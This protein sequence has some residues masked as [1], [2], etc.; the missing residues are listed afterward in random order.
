MDRWQRSVHRDHRDSWVSPFCFMADAGFRFDLV[1][2]ALRALAVTLGCRIASS[3]GTVNVEYRI[4]TRQS[5]S[6]FADSPLFVA[7]TRRIGRSLETPPLDPVGGD[8]QV[9]NNH[10][11]SYRGVN[12]LQRCR[13]RSS[14]NLDILDIESCENSKQE[15]W[16]NPRSA[17]SPSTFTQTASMPV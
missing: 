8:V 13:G 1:L 2:H 14:K 6:M 4:A 3:R 15:G 11:R 10:P 17:L 5:S 16:Y 7:R 9:K 12:V